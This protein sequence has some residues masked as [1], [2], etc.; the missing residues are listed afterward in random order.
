MA[1]ALGGLLGRFFVQLKSFFIIGL[2]DKHE[3]LKFLLLTLIFALVIGSY[4]IAKELKDSLFVSI[5][6]K[7][8]LP[9]AKF[10][11]IFLLIPAALAYS[12]L[13][14]VFRRY[15]LLAFYSALYGVILA[16]FTVFLGHSTIG[17]YNS[18]ASSSRIFGWLFY[19]IMEG[20]APFVVSVFWAFLNSISSPEEA[21]NTYPMM[22][23]GSKL[24]GIATAF[25]AWY[26]LGNAD[27]L[28]RF[29]DLNHDVVSH[30]ILM[31]LVSVMLLVVPILLV[32][33]VK[34]VPGKYL[35]G[36]EAVYRLEKKQQSDEKTV[37]T[38]IFSGIRL[39]M[40]SPYVLGIF[41]LVFFYETLNVL[42]NFQ[43][44]GM[45]KEASVSIAGFTA[46]MF[47]QRIQMHFWTMIISFLGVQ[48]LFKKLE[49]RYCLL[50]VPLSVLFLLAF[51][52]LTYSAE[53]ILY[54]FIGLGAINHSLSYPLRET[55][56]IPATKDMKFKAKAW[57]DTFGTKFSKGFG[58]L[59]ANVANRVSVVSGWLI[60]VYGVFFGGL[61]V[62]WF[63]ASWLLGKTYDKAIKN[64]EIIGEEK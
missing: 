18:E 51:F 38:S 46:A 19:I 27:W 25:L 54:V 33:L 45:L 36:Y 23:A 59:F 39:L 44:I 30:Q 32:V 4:T 22:V 41:G 49:V 57:I 11:V 10:L 63:I 20:Y 37:K 42:L 14:D 3:R 15:Q 48:F 26:L 52:V 50:L 7:E 58:S 16:V 40:E 6:G 64:N 35:H 29:G 56:Y 24:G 62:M 12:R 55:L 21:K 61:M 43:R 17:L 1:S 47:W 9:T 2:Q 13:V 34:K 28:R 60:V 53:S 5:V 31:A 8:Y